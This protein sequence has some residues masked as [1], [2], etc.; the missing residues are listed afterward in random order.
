MNMW[1][2]LKDK[3]NI[4]NEAWH[5]IAM[6]SDDPPCLNKIIKHMK[7]LNQTWKIKPTPGEAEGVQISFKESII[8]HIRS[9]K[10]SG[11]IHDGD[12]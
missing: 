5:E 6:K 12:T 8:E 11:V 10:A 7:K 3:F 4:S 1:L 9:L 2:N